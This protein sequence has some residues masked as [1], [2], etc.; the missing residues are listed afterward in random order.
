MA[1]LHTLDL[2]ALTAFYHNAIN[3]SNRK[4][5][6]SQA[7]LHPAANESVVLMPELDNIV[8]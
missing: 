7:C 6:L 8:P 4:R 1:L 2:L 5:G 3:P